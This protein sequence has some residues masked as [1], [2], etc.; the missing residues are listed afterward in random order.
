MKILAISTDRKVFEESSAV[1][2]RLLDYGR[3]VDELHVIVFTKKSQGFHEDSFAHNIFL[4]PTNARTRWGYIYHAVREGTKL[5]RRG[6]KI[7]VVTAQDPFEVG[8]VAFILSRVLKAKL[9][10][11]VHTDFL[12][13]YFSRESVINRKRVFLAKFLLRRADAIRVVSERIKRSLQGVTNTETL[14]AVLPIFVDV[15]KYT[16]A[17]ISHSLKVKYPQFEKHI[18]MASRLS[19]E[20][21]ISLA[22][23]AM[24]DVVIKYPKTG[25][26][27]TGSGHEEGYLKK[28]VHD[29]GLVKNIIFEEWQ[30]NLAS[31]YKSADMFLITSNYEGYGMTAIE[32][33]ASECPV[34]MTD[35]GCAGYV[36][37]HGE[38]GLVVPV[39]D[40]EALE[41]AIARVISGGVNLTATLPK[42]PTKEEYLAGY[43]KS[44]EDARKKAYFC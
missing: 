18:L 25:L 22:I 9:H 19:T 28:L 42:L 17:K 29:L 36:V 23:R 44:W 7:D 13:P 38:N 26:I 6:I 35:V 34:V 39:G 21:N 37:L 16:N 4:Y 31:Y 10:L 27:I 32:A 40:K 12:S 8:F 2:S 24:K 33:L 15:E 11:Q 20:K 5:K 3:L 41:R 30:N 14:I 43:K 1:R